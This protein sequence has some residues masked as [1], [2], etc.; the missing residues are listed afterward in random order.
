MRIDRLDFARQAMAILP[1]RVK[2]H[3]TYHSTT[4]HCPGHWIWSD[5]ELEYLYT[6]GVLLL[7]HD[8]EL[9]A[10]LDV[11]ASGMGKVLS[12]G[13]QPKRP[14]VPP[15]VTCLKSGEWITLTGL[16]PRASVKRVTC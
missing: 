2:G 3:G 13:W 12:I 15:R 5:G 9:S 7:P 14:W 1:G 4:P 16:K 8:L 6:E 11:L 10:L